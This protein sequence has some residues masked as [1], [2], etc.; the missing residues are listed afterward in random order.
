MC[1]C[2]CLLMRHP[3]IVVAGAE[4]DAFMGEVMSA[5]HMRCSFPTLPR[6]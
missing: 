5:L 6:F 2:C 4:F 1:A 3:S